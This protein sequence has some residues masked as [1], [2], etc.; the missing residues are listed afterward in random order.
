MVVILSSRRAWNN[1]ETKTIMLMYS[2]FNTLHSNYKV[3]VSILK[4][5]LLKQSHN[6]T[7]LLI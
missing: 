4:I 6:L 2:V 3:K 1:H 5:L 7:E